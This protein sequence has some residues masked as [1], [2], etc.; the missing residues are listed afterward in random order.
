VFLQA[1]P[2]GT[3]SPSTAVQRPSRRQPSLFAQSWSDA[4]LHVPETAEQRPKFLQMSCAVQ[5]SSV[6][7]QAPSFS[8]QRA[9]V[10]HPSLRRQS[11]SSVATHWSPRAVHC[12]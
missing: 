10:V 9:C 3:H 4:K 11:G 12:P 2:R 5:L 7:T 8:V 1:S 6:A